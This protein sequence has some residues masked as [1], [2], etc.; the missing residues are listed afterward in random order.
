MPAVKHWT[1]FCLKPL[2]LSA[3]HPAVH[4]ACAISM[5]R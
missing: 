1:A 4:L 3:R 2:Q 5:C